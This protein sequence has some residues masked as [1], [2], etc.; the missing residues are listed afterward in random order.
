M[1]YEILPKN[2]KIFCCD[3][4]AFNTSNK[5]NYLKHLDTRKHKIL[6]NT[7][8]NL[9]KN[10]TQLYECLCG[11]KYKHKQS[12]Y[13]HKKVC[14]SSVKLSEQRVEDYNIDFKELVCKMMTENNE[15]KNMLLKENQELRTQIN[16]LIPKVGTHNSITNSSIT[17]S[18]VTNSSI[19]NNKFNIQIFLNEQCKDAINMKDFIESIKISLQQLDLIQSKGL[20]EGLT[21]AILE[22]ISKLSLYKRPIHCTDIKRETLYIKHDDIWEKDK[23]KESIKKAI[24]ELCHKPYYT[25]KEWLDNNP[26]YMDDENKQ[27][28]FIQT[29]R[30]LGKKCDTFDDKVIKNICSNTY[31]KEV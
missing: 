24:K 25:L 4:C 8:Q 14:L 12:L 6:T 1:T 29:T 11:K 27:H 19:T 30:S 21:N 23:T 15:I 16:E 20:A 31:I 5:F 17:N 28:Y 2:A 26:N 10:A 22:N 18:S 9:A 3:K 13:S 7:Y